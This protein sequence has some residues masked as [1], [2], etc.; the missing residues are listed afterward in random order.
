M[1]AR[2]GIRFARRI[3]DMVVFAVHDLTQDPPLARLDLVS[4]RNLLIYL[5]PERQDRALRVLHYGLVPGGY[6]VLGALETTAELHDRFSTVDAKLSIYAKRSPTDLA[7]RPVPSSIPALPTRD[8]EGRPTAPTLEEQSLLSSKERRLVQ[9]QRELGDA[10]RRL[11]TTFEDLECANEELQSM[12]EE[13]RSSNEEL[14]GTNEE[15]EREK[16]ELQAATEELVGVNDELQARIVELRLAND[17]IH[18]LLDVTGNAVVI[19]GMDGRIRRLNDTA[20]RLLNLQS[21]DVATPLSR[22]THPSARSN[23]SASWVRSSS[24]WSPSTAR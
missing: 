17:D 2:A 21:G 10:R 22:L 7:K 24:R 6:L 14:E 15:L 13:L 1:P 8:D 9:L 16:E 4:C 5:P 20:R 18:N 23:C 11:R 19:V 3:R 12:V